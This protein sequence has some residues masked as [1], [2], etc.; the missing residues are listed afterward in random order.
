[1]ALAIQ[2]QTVA[3]ARA[4]LAELGIDVAA[5]VQAS[6]AATA[7]G[8][9]IVGG[10]ANVKVDGSSHDLLILNNGLVLVPCPKDTD[11]GRD[12]MLHMVQSASVTAIAAHGRFIGYEEVASARIVKVVPA[13]VELTLH[14]GRAVKLHEAWSGDLLTKESRDNLFAALAP[15]RDAQIG[16]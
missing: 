5:A 11:G 9:D 4:R 6:A 13:K 1:V 15:F 12:R 16:A 7:A 10:L 8:A 3:Q 14:S 2:P